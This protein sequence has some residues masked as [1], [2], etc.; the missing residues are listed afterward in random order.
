MNLYS[1][2]SLLYIAKTCSWLS[3][4]DKA[5]FRFDSLSFINKY[6]ATHQDALPKKHSYV[7]IPVFLDNTPRGLLQRYQV[8]EQ[9]TAS[10]FR[11][12]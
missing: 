11:A 9:L 1:A 7:N 3:P 10:I 4:T 6:F 5:V 12:V 2:W 8:S